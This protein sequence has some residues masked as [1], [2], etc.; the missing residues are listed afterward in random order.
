MPG[1]DPSADHLV[2]PSLIMRP[3]RHRGRDAVWAVVEPPLPP[4]PIDEHALGCHRPRVPEPVCFEGILVR[5]VTGSA[6]T[7]KLSWATGY[8]TLRRGTGVTM[9][10]TLVLTAKLIDWRGRCSP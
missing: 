2:E 1:A 4:I 8:P 10:V 7:S 3:V 9:A 6:S 5:L